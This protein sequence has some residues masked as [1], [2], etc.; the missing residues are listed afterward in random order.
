MTLWAVTSYYNPVPYRRRLA[1]YRT[2]RE[3]LAL[4]LLT[5]ELAYGPAPELGR[6]DADILVQ[7]HGRDVMWQK[8][9]LLNL[10]V[11]ALPPE[12]DRVAWLDCDI[13][14]EDRSWV[15]RLEA[16]LETCALVQPFSRVHYLTR[17]WTPGMAAE[18]ATEFSRLSLI[19]A[20]E[21]GLPPLDGL[22]KRLGDRSKTSATGFAWAGHRDLVGRHGLYD[23]AI[24]GAGDR[25]LASASYGCIDAAADLLMMDDRARAHFTAWAGPWKEALAGRV[26]ALA[27]DVLNLWHGALEHRGDAERHRALRDLGFDPF[28]DIALDDAGAWRWASDKPAL[29][30]YLRDYFRARREDG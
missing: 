8:E 6:G 1:N 2:F 5:V 16:K 26:G 7:I 15:Q 30:A 22:A 11:A 27:G 24:T 23:A 13:V 28:G 10:A 14:F 21:G 29:H 25:L 17:D 3:Q 9:R 19:A 18:T 12:C 20:I 4:P